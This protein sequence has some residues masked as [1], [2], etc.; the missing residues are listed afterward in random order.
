MLKR[1][2]KALTSASYGLTEKPHHHAMCNRCWTIIEVPAQQLFTAL[3]HVIEGSAFTLS[4][5][6]GLILHGRCP[7]FQG[8][9]QTPIRFKLQRRD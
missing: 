2:G 1:R 8:V 9:G 3:A 4:E 7:D 6:A 5:Q